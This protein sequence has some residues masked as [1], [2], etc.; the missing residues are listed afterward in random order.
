MT[1]VGKSLIRAAKE[2]AN[3]AR[4]DPLGDPIEHMVANFEAEIERLRKALEEI[5]ATFNNPGKE[6]EACMIA[7][8]ALKPQRREG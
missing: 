5:S 3:I 8:A 7:Y 1:Q 4:D 6:R 2:A